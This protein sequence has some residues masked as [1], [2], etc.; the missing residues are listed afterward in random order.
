MYSMRH[1]CVGNIVTL[2][3]GTRMNQVSGHQAPLCHG[4]MLKIRRAGLDV[5]LFLSSRTLFILVCIPLSCIRLTQMLQDG[6]QLACDGFVL[7]V[8]S[9]WK[10]SHWVCHFLSHPRRYFCVLH[11]EASCVRLIVVVT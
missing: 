7:C 11:P 5:V 9:E 1:D 3:W 4:D 8:Q 2:A 6:S 10:I